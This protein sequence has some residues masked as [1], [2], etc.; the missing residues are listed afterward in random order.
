MHLLVL[1]PGFPTHDGPFTPS[2]VELLEQLGQRHAVTVYAIRPPPERR[3]EW[4][5]RGITVRAFGTGLR[6]RRL[7]EIVAHA[8]LGPTPDVVWSLWG[9]RTGLLAAALGR[10]LR[11]PVV[12]SLL[13]GELADEPALD[14]GALRRFKW[15]SEL[16][17]ALRGAARITV[18]STEMERRLARAWP[19]AAFA[20][21][22]LGVPRNVIPKRAARDPRW[23]RRLL[24]VS[25]L[26]PI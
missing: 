24:T 3:G 26:S 14:Y 20:R 2:I 6:E 1:S 16:A 7:A 18:G 23:P 21:T 13:G 12:V 25:H 10:V 22:P 15:R 11:R 9:D 8:A 17:L 19:R 5:H 4:T